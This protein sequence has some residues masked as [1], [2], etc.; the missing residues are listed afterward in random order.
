MKYPSTEPILALPVRRT[1]WW[2]HDWTLTLYRDTGWLRL[3][4]AHLCVS[5]IYAVD[6]VAANE[7]ES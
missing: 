7:D 1:L 4:A 2:V 3:G 5:L 6:G